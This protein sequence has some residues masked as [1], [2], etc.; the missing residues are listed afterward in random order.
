MNIAHNQ[1]EYTEQVQQYELGSKED[2][3]E[4]AEHH[5]NLAKRNLIE[6]A[7]WSIGTI[8]CAGLTLYAGHEVVTQTGIQDAGNLLAAGGGTL[9]VS[10]TVS[11]TKDSINEMFTN[12]K[13]AGRYETLTSSAPSSAHSK[14]Q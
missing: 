2:F 1:V 6:V 12:A 5:T 4:Q 13:R 10:M 14:D 7:A 8:A 9:L 3:L 11:E